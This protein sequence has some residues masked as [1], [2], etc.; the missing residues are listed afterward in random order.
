M[1]DQKSGK[2]RDILLGHLRLSRLDPRQALAQ[3]GDRSFAASGK[4]CCV[5]TQ[6]LHAE[7]ALAG[8]QRSVLELDQRRVEVDSEFF[9]ALHQAGEFGID[10][11][12]GLDV[13]GLVACSRRRV[14]VGHVGRKRAQ[15]LALD[16]QQ[17]ARA[18]AGDR[19]QHFV[20][21]EAA[22]VDD[23]LQLLGVGV[24]HCEIGPAH[25]GAKLHGGG[26]KDGG[27]SFGAGVLVHRRRLER[28]DQLKRPDLVALPG[29][30]RSG[31]VGCKEAEIGLRQQ[32]R[33]GV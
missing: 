24:E 3:A 8:I 20:G 6:D 31:G 10:V 17:F 26:A 14:E 13:P 25:A 28:F 27:R 15:L 4:R 22:G 19:L 2:R 1:L 30:M 12:V 9:Q 5:H 23:K 32:A 18:L 11:L 7:Q 29:R 21:E 16:R 33:E